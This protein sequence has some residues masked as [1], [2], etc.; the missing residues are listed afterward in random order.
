MNSAILT[1]TLLQTIPNTIIVIVLCVYTLFAFVAFIKIKRL[2]KW[3]L[4]LRAYNFPR[5]ALIH[6]ILAIIGLLMAFI[7]LFLL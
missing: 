4:S 2:E 7:L 3:L 5:Y 6:L 1:T